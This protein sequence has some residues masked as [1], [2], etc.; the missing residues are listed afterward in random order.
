MVEGHGED[1]KQREEHDT[2]KADIRVEIRQVRWLVNA[3]TPSKEI[4]GETKAKEKRATNE[5][6]KSTHKCLK[7]AI[8]PLLWI[9]LIVAA[10]ATPERNGSAPNPSQL[11]QAAAWRPSVLVRIIVE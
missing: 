11:H 2:G 1:K 5:S 7:V 9:P 10:V 4:R 8:T 3:Y 6:L